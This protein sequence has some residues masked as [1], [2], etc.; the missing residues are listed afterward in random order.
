MIRPDRT[1]GHRVRY[2]DVKTEVAFGA[3]EDVVVR[4]WG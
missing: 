4:Y 3:G 1:G 2:R